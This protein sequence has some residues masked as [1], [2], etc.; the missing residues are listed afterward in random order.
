MPMLL[1]QCDKQ[2]AFITRAV[3]CIEQGGRGSGKLLV[4][5]SGHMFITSGL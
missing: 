4:M 2:P 3:G 1:Q 5:N